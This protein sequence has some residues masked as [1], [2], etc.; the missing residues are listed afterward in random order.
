MPAGTV[1][2][3]GI[4]S[5]LRPLSDTR[6][7]APARR[8]PALHGAER[9]GRKQRRM[10]P[11]RIRPVRRQDN[12]GYPPAP[13]YRQHRPY[14]IPDRPPFVEGMPEVPAWTATSGLSSR[15]NCVL[16]AT[17]LGQRCGNHPPP[18]CRTPW[19]TLSMPPLWVGRVGREAGGQHDMNSSPTLPRAGRPPA[20]VLP[21]TWPDDME[22]G[23]D[24]HMLCGIA[25]RCH[26]GTGA[27]WPARAGDGTGTNP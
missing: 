14:A 21:L 22:P 10:S 19:V 16:S 6:V 15:G 27:T 7:D 12:R 25:D 18:A 8:Y 5:P 11:S 2:H 23:I 4:T 26:R 3:A 1:F 24:D 20:A 9:R 17:H 13:G